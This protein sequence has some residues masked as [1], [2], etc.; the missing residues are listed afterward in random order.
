MDSVAVDPASD[1]ET[2][3]IV[4]TDT[5]TAAR[6]AQLRT[7]HGVIETPVFMPVATQGTVKGLTGA[8]VEDLGAKIL[9]ANAYH[10]AVRPGVETIVALGGLHRFMGWTGAILTDSGGYQIMSLAGL[11]KVDEQ[12]V[13]F[14]SHVDGAQVAFTPEA[15]V[16]LQVRLGV[17][18][19]M[20]LDECV[21]AHVDHRIVQAAAERTLRWAERSRAV[22][23]PDA[24]R[25]LFGIVQGGLVE[26]VRQWHAAQLAAL[27]FPGYAVGGLS[28]GEERE[29][30]RRVASTTASALPRNRPRYLMGVGLPQDLLRFIGMGYDMFDCVLPT[31]NGRNGTYFTSFGRLNI[32]RAEHARANEPVDPECA[33]YT[34]RN[35]S[36]GYLRHLSM[37]GEMLA[38]QLATLHNVHFYLDLMATA[39][40]QIVAG[41]FAAW[42]AARIAAME[43][44]VAELA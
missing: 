13:V 15:I 7:G 16:E 19:L 42:S 27:D 28:V 40:R 14:R 20:P 21:P 5:P 18:I 1:L 39:R 11:R 12:G 34:C 44:P 25:L 24:S 31:R 38:A 41:S 9:L 33:C 8:Q 4:Q 3:R 6:T 26:D 37:A 10:L 43:P 17:D 30:T 35:F 32:R 22:R 2:F 29:T 23:L 36:R